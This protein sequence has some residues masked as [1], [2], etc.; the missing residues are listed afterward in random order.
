MPAFMFTNVVFILIFI[1]MSIAHVRS[2]SAWVVFIAAWCIVDSLFA[3]KIHLEW[4]KWA[5]LLGALTIIDLL[6]IYFTR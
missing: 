6:V 3:S 1:W 2:I 5:L 4:W